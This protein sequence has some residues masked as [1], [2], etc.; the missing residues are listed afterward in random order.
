[1]HINKTL[2]KRNF[3]FL[4][5]DYTM[6]MKSSSDNSEKPSVVAVEYTPR[7]LYLDIYH[8]AAVLLLCSQN[9]PIRSDQILIVSREKS[10]IF[11]RILEILEDILSIAGITNFYETEVDQQSCMGQEDNQNLGLLVHGVMNLPKVP[12]PKV[13]D[14][15]DFWMCVMPSTGENFFEALLYCRDIYKKK[16]SMKSN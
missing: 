7:V 16:K 3:Q 13:P 14:D 1:M 6:T 5:S 10:S 15:L 11:S 4:G 8:S 2:T 9:K 12:E